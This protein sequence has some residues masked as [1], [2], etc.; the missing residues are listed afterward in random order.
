MKHTGL[1]YDKIENTLDRDHFMT[2]DEAKEF[3]LID[4][5]LISRDDI[6]PDG[7]SSGKSD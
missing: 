4:K 6:E 7:A 1:S 3:G 5:V 2:A